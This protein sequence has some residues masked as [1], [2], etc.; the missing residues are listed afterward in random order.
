M[1]AQTDDITGSLAQAGECTVT[2]RAK[3]SKGD[4]LKKFEIVVGETISLTPPM[5]WNSWNHYGGKITADIHQAG[6]GKAKVAVYP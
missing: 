5:D 3:N 6:C 1:D 2:L 4:A